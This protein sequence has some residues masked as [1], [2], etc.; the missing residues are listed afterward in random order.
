[1]IIVT[2][3]TGFI[4]SAMVWQLNNRGFSSVIAV[5]TVPPSV[6]PGPLANRRFERFIGKDDLWTFLEKPEFEKSVNAVVHMGAC[7]STTEL[8]TAFLNEN[9]FQYTKRLWQWCAKKQK[10]FIYASSGAVYGNGDQGFDDGSPS[11]MFKPLNPYG[12]SKAMFDCWVENET[13]NMSALM[14]PSWYGL[15]FFNVFGPNEYLKG[16]MASVV[17]KAFHQIRNTG[18]LKLF[19]SHRADYRDGE[20]LRDFVYIK[21]IVRWMDE[22]VLRATGQ[23]ASDFGPAESGIYNMGYGQARSWNDL[24]AATFRGLEKPIAIDYIDIPVEMRPRY[25]YFTQ[26]NIQRLMSLN[27]TQPQW[28]LEKAVQDY[29]YN[30]LG[31]GDPWL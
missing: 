18:K 27:L 24:A 10:P 1:M 8:D 26:A 30:H 25:Q 2:G 14:P 6:R 20:Q 29:V 21:D 13:R 5:D 31:Q 7:S 11:T 15:R 28:P 9:N 22:L 3:A 4:G 23:A 16:D 12:E 17:F 19:K